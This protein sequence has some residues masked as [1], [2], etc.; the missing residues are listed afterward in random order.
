VCNASNESGVINGRL[1][2]LAFGSRL[3]DWAILNLQFP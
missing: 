1:A 2:A 3:N